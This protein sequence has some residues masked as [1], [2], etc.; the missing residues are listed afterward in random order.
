MNQKVFKFINNACVTMN[1]SL[2]EVCF[3]F[4]YNITMT[5]IKMVAIFAA[6]V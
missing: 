3:A 2:F 1:H 5:A 6:A 4:Q